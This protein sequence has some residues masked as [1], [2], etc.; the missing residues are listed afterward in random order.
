MLQNPQEVK[1]GSNQ[2]EISEK[3]H[4]S[5]SAVSP[6]TLTNMMITYSLNEAVNGS[7]GRLLKNKMSIMVFINSCHGAVTAS[8]GE[9][10]T[11]IM[12]SMLQFISIKTSL[13]IVIMYVIHYLLTFPVCGSDGKTW[14]AR[15][16]II[17]CFVHL[18]NGSVSESEYRASVRVTVAINA[19]SQPS[20]F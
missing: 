15:I 2:A 8:N 18:C 11:V 7:V 19:L 12:I 14:D 10:N 16:S 5:E 4:G 9:A 20:S 6:M 13:D 1:S 3:D 17:K